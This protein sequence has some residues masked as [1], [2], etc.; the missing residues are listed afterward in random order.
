MRGF[1]SRVFACV[2]QMLKSGPWHDTLVVGMHPVRSEHT[3]R[4]NR[5]F[6]LHPLSERQGIMSGFVIGTAFVFAATRRAGLVSRKNCRRSKM[7]QARPNHWV[8]TI[9]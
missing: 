3:C 8:Q 5:I 4:L 7:S 9:R 6:Q 2:R 1:A